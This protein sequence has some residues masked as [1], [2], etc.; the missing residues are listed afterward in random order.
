MIWN[1]ASGIIIAIIA[2]GASY[3]VARTGRKTAKESQGVQALA[4]SVNGFKALLDETRKTHSERIEA[5]QSQLNNQ[6]QEHQKTAKELH[7]V[8]VE[9][10]ELKRRMFVL[11]RALAAARRYIETLLNILQTNNI[12]VPN[13]PADYTH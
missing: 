6:E 9:K 2:G 1:I 7:A 8:A 4:E 11:E 12:Q 13:P 3:L 5:L 10:D